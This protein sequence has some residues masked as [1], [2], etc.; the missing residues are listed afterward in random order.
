MNRIRGWPG[1]SSRLIAHPHEMLAAVEK[2]RAECPGDTIVSI[3]AVAAKAK[4]H[5]PVPEKSIKHFISRGMSEAKRNE[6]KIEHP[7]RKPLS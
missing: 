5:L 6:L 3:A 7:K 2:G 4:S 1:D